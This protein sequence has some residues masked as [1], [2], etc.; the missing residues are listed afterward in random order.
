MMRLIED[1]GIDCDTQMPLTS[2]KLKDPDADIDLEDCINQYLLCK[3]LSGY[4][5]CWE[6]YNR[7]YGPYINIAFYSIYLIGWLYIILKN[8]PTSLTIII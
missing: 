3:K 6:E 5:Q 2:F 4:V 1:K 8:I 7:Y